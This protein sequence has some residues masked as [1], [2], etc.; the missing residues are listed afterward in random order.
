MAFPPD[1]GQ[2]S[3]SFTTSIKT[4]SAAAYAVGSTDATIRAN[5][6]SNAVV[7]TLMGAAAAFGKIITVKKIDVTANM[8]TIAAAFGETID[9]SASLG[10]SN[11]ESSFT[12]QS[13]GVSWDIVASV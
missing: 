12:V 7:I 13:N 11:Q 10:I 4:V 3:G 2:T 1:P 8:V 6:V 5:A 9:G